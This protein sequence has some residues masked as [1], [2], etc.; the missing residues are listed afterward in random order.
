MPIAWAGR[1]D[2]LSSH[3][4]GWS[5]PRLALSPMSHG[6]AH[7][8][9]TA[10]RV[11]QGTATNNARSSRIS[12]APTLY[13]PATHNSAEI[14]VQNH[15]RHAIPLPLLGSDFL[16]GEVVMNKVTKKPKKRLCKGISQQQVTCEAPA[17]R[18]CTQCG[19]WFCR[20]HFPDPDWHQC[21]PDQ[22]SG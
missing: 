3:L 22:G 7:A 18:R 15:P 13:S 6:T 10:R 4:A 14:P 21:A 20:I 8:H 9:Q 5:R 17:Q 19:L 16:R 1:S 12:G 2:S 11:L